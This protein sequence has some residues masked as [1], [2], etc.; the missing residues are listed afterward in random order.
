MYTYIY[1]YMSIFVYI[2]YYIYIYIHSHTCIYI[3]TN[4]YTQTHTHPH[5]NLYI[6]YTNITWNLC[7]RVHMCLCCCINGYYSHFVLSKAFEVSRVTLTSTHVASLRAAFVTPDPTRIS[8]YFVC[9]I[10]IRGWCFFVFSLSRALSL[11]VCVYCIYMSIFTHIYHVCIYI[12]CIHMYVCERE[13]E[14]ACMYMCVCVCL[15]VRECRHRDTSTT[16]PVSVAVCV[17]VC[18]YAC[19]CIC[20]DLCVR[21][22]VCVYAGT[23]TTSPISS[24]A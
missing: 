24:A 22:C 12:S 18:V 13:R 19:V 21:V 15:W 14:Y 16:S 11:S 4:I 7:F 23:S 6:L 9:L 17:C 20:V 5:I 2:L 10:Y 1:I 8:I 3:Q